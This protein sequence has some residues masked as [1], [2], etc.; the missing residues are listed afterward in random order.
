MV[1]SLTLSA[2]LQFTQELYLII[3]AEVIIK[4]VIK[5]IFKI[6]I[7][8]HHLHILYLINKVPF[9]KSI[10]SSI[11]KKN[12]AIAELILNALKF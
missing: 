3:L 4:I 11:N 2:L 9:A 10:S 1:S 6:I 7:K 12:S 5:I 8:H